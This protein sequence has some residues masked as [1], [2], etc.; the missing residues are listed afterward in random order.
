ML[1]LDISTQ[2]VFTTKN[3]KSEPFSEDNHLGQKT[4][5]QAA[6]RN[7]AELLVASHVSVVFF[8]GTSF[9][10]SVFVTTGRHDLSE[11]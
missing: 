3:A 7:H 4:R 9:F 8:G 2:E 11:S 5:N 1:P 10:R 6:K